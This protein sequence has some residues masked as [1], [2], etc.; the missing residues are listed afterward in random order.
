MQR[1]FC[2]S[3]LVLF[4]VGF[5]LTAWSV[6]GQEI[7]VLQHS[8]YFVN[9]E[10]VSGMVEALASRG[11]VDGQNISITYY[12]AEA[13]RENA[14]LLAAE[15]VT[16]EYDLILTTSTPCLQAVAQANQTA[17]IPHVFC[18]VS[19]AYVADVGIASPSDKPAYMTGVSTPNPVG[20]AIELAQQIFPSL[21]KLGITW[22]PAEA[23]SAFTTQLARDACPG[24]G[25]ELLERT[26]SESSEVFQA[27]TALV[28]E[29]VQAI[30][31]GGDNTVNLAID[32]VVQAA[33]NGQIP[34]FTVN[35]HSVYSGALFDLG[36]N[37]YMVGLRAGEKAADI[38]SGVDPET[39]P[40]EDYVPEMLFINLEALEGLEP[41]WEI[42]EEILNQADEII[43]T[44]DAPGWDLYR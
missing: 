3:R 15:I 32:D 24:L 12:N 20:P 25:I 44:S 4:V 31:M 2:R 29:G 10:G 22:N 18:V 36:P 40:A 17:R 5:L 13:S 16:A 6:W 39:I 8:A 14:D 1:I 27:E 37:F 28:A 26:V 19:S 30:L 41:P 43:G 42:P 38:L 7:A 33:H 11:Y 23:N 34:V 35:V 21:T 9:D